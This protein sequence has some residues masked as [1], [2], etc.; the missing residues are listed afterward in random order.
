MRIVY[1]AVLS[2]SSAAAWAVDF[3]GVELGE[4]CR[5]AAQVET[6]LGTQPHQDVE[7]MIEYNIVMFEDHSTAGQHARF[8]YSCRQNPGLISRYSMDIRTRSEPLAWELYAA[9]KAAAISRLG[10]PPEDSASPD[11]TARLGQLRAK[12]LTSEYAFSNWKSVA[13]QSV[14]V[15]IEKAPE[16]EEWSIST[17][18]SADPGESPNKSLE[19]TRDK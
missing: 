8:L 14:F 10:I 18:V 17:I 15:T 19:R 3:R 9:A 5:Q 13:H 11:A 1:L 2:A 6:S 4:T 12:G 7:S 16:D